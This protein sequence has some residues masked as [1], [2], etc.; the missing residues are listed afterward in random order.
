MMLHNIYDRWRAFMV[1]SPF[2]R[3]EWPQLRIK[4]SILNGKFLPLRNF[5]KTTIFFLQI[6]AAS[7]LKNKR[8]NWG[9]QRNWLGD[10]LSLSSE[11]EES[12]KYSTAV[13]ATQRDER[14]N[15]VMF[16][17]FVRKTNKFNK[18][19]DRAILVTDNAIYKLDT[20]K[21]KPMKKGMPIQEV[22]F[23]VERMKLFI[24][25]CSFQL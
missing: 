6:S 4:V 12:F 21:F 16:S 23:T 9:S 8:S 24:K 18:C 22:K 5:L 14:F 15:K 7:A 2:P 1:L 20:M 3:E 13:R 17:S 11:H 10:Y 25:V 19:A